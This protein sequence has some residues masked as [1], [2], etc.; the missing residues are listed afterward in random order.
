MKFYSDLYCKNDSMHGCTK[1]TLV[2]RYERA[3]YCGTMDELD[4]GHAGDMANP[5]KN[6]IA[7]WAVLY[8]TVWEYHIVSVSAAAPDDA[9]AVPL[10]NGI[11]ISELYVKVNDIDKL[12]ELLRAKGIE[13]E[14]FLSYVG[15]YE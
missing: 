6:V 9:C 8:A 10:T 14:K 4:M 12:K 11:Y 1:V 7:K 5:V 13:I 15:W 3:I 2:D